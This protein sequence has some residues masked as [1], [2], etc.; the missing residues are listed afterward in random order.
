MAD[1]FRS[2]PA[3]ATG[4]GRILRSKRVT[5]F[6]ALEDLLACSEEI[7]GVHAEDV[8]DV[9]AAAAV[10]LQRKYMGERKDLYRRYLAH[11][12]D[13][14]VLT[15]EESADLQHLAD[16][17]HLDDREIAPV[18][19]DLAQEVYGMAIRE[20]LEDLRLDPDEETFLRRLRGELHI[21]DEVAQRL[22]ERGETE[23]R[24]RAYSKAAAGVK[25][26]VEFRPPAGDF[27]GRSTSSLE[28]AVADAL[29]KATVAVPKLHWF[30]L[31]NISGYVENGKPE[32][33]HVTV[34]A[35][36]KPGS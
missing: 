30:E 8:R 5:T 17:L 9:C 16:L 20:V 11:C 22:Y 12:L 14:K 13:D 27:T 3:A 1:P 25:E 35:G 24:D 10:D 21:S 31:T 36:L 32:S 19:E 26:F 4:L 18:H 6:E 34:R 28:M 2:A 29:T 15:E 7:R 33:W 23:A